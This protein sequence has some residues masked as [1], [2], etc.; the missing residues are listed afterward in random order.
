VQDVLGWYFECG[1]KMV[2]Q[3]EVTGGM[4]NLLTLSF[5]ST[6][7]KYSCVGGCFIGWISTNQTRGG[8]V[9]RIASLVFGT[10]FFEQTLVILFMTMK[11]TNGVVMLA[12]NA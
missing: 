6:T 2:N 5:S 4:V 7:G 12:Y 3:M 10:H 1:G 8:Y 9:V 11:A